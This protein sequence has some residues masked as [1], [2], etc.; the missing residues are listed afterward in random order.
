MAASKAR[1]RHRRFLAHTTEPPAKSSARFALAQI[2]MWKN[3]DGVYTADPRRVPEAFPIE[4]LKYDEAIELAF[5]GAQVL[6]PSAMAPCIEE[7]IPIFVRNIFNPA[8]P[9]TVIEGRACSLESSAEAW[10]VE[11][12]AARAQ[13][14]KAACPVKLRDNESPIRGITSVDQVSLVSIEGAQLL[15]L[16][17]V[18]QR[19]FGAIREAGAQVI[20]ITQASADSSI[21]V[22][23]PTSD[24][25]RALRCIEAA[26]QLE[27]QRKQVASI[28]CE[29]GHSVVAIVGEG[30]AFRPG[31]GATFTKAMANAGV[32]IRAIAQGSSE[33]QISICV[34]DVDCTRALRA[35]HAALALSNTQLSVAIVGASGMVGTELLSQ[36]ASAGSVVGCPGVEKSASALPVD[37]KVTALARS[38][39]MILSYDGID[40]SKPQEDLW[41]GEAER[42]RPDR[43]RQ[44]ALDLDELTNHLVDDYNGN[45]VVIDVTASQAVSDYYER[46]LAAGM[47]V[48]TANKKAGSGPYDAYENIV[49]LGSGQARNAQWYYETTGPGSGLPVLSTLKDMVQSGDVIQRVEG[50]FSG[51][52]SYLTNQ[53]GEGVALSEAL[54]KAANLG[55]MEPD[56]R[57]DLCAMDVRRKIVV[58]ARELGLR[59]ELDDV[60]CE[61]FL[62][63]ELDSWEPQVGAEAPPLVEQL[64]A[65][66]KPHD[67]AMHDR[68][69]AL[70]GPNVNSAVKI[71]PVC[72]VDVYA[73]TAEFKME[74][75]PQSNALTR[76]VSNDNIIAIL[77]NRYSPQ[78]LIIQGPGA[79]AA[80]TAS[81]LYADLLQLTRTLEDS[82]F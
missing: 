50:V 5:F 76:C 26:F 15:G 68:L 59:I 22:V 62:P 54:L 21:C 3:V 1:E 23:T 27:L 45:L 31:V 32:N 77:S 6:H 70:T 48:I 73:G 69:A 47:H 34:E 56:P 41:A 67:G 18:S 10:S 71:V 74:A 40:V 37:M 8:H 65:V 25:E 72:R 13:N 7:R 38:D 39:T 78:P 4:S 57:D 36:L 14:R 64:A 29:H 51:T 49:R 11:A 46:W 75:L 30:M 66:L 2:T 33:R 9:G 20:M 12:V 55:Y 61:S 16:A 80:V 42:P 35:A 58:L 52:L 44:A 43:A 24:A 63:A 81:G 53:M 19:L 28:T 60:S 82:F 79:G 17:D